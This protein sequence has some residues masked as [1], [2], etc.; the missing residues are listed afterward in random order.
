MDE[1]A[2]GT[3]FQEIIIKS[4][5]ERRFIE[6]GATV[7][8]T[9][10]ANGGQD[11]ADH[12]ASAERSGSSD[13]I[14]EEHRELRQTLDRLEATPEPARL[15]SVLEDL[16]RQLEVHFAEEEGEEG[17]VKAIDTSNAQSVRCLERL[18]EE[19]KH[20]VVRI[21]DLAKRLRALRSEVTA[22]HGELRHLCGELRAHEERENQ[23]LTESVLT[24][25]GTGD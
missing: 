25:V 19:H 5:I 14:A 2:A 18:F 16:G 11:M 6:G 23:L 7:T 12:P 10:H 13:S 9:P 17:L 20:F 8:G 15:V 4:L 21:D 1:A 3:H 22:V 24:D